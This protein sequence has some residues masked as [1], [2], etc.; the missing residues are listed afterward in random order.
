MPPLLKRRDVPRS[1][2]KKSAGPRRFIDLNNIKLNN[3]ELDS[4]KSSV[5]VAEIYRYE[6]LLPISDLVYNGNVVILDC[7][8]IQTED[9]LMKR[10]TD[11]V[12]SISRDQGGDVAALS[13]DLIIVT[14]KGIGID[15]NKIRGAFIRTV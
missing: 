6:D 15:R 14:P 7:N 3:S 11:E 10:V 5:K 1:A 8:R 4:I 9:G 13:R 12:L 2:P